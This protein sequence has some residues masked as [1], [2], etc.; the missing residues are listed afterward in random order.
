MSKPALVPAGFDGEIKDKDRA[1]GQEGKRAEGQEG[2][3]KREKFTKIITGIVIRYY[4]F[5][6][7]CII[8]II[9]SFFI[10]FNLSNLNFRFESLSIQ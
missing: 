4:G 2:K 7:F 9:T 6:I 1:R 10:E 8:G 3:G 5:A